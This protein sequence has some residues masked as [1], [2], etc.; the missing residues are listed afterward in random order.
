MYT[1]WGRTTIE[2]T[3]KKTLFC[4]RPRFQRRSGRS[5][6]MASRNSA[7]APMSSEHIGMSVIAC[8]LMKK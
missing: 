4:D 3:N 1:S 5:S 2:K 7:I 6:K 8:R